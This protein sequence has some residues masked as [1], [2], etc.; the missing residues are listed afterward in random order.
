MR[1]TLTVFLIF[2]HVVSFAQSHAEYVSEKCDSMALI[3]K[4]DIDVIN[5]VFKERTHLDSLNVING[6]LITTL[7]LK[8]N[9]LRSIVNK[10]SLVIYNN[11]L[12]IASLEKR[13]LMSEK[14]YKKLIKKEKAKTI[15][16]QTT[17]GLSIITIILILL[18]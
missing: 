1:K 9:V 6:E 16:F 11:E 8:N 18:L 12:T 5:R 2:I 13:H 17:T 7:E 10:Q 3:S 4:T 14:E 15:T